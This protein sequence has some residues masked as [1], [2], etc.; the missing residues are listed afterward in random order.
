MASIGGSGLDVQGIVSQ[1]MNIER[2][3]LRLIDRKIS[4]QE[5]KISALGRLSSSLTDLKN[6]ADKLQNSSKFGQFKAESSDEKVLTASASSLEVEET[7]SIE[8]IAL[9]TRHRV[10]SE[11]VYESSA[12]SVGAGS[13][14]FSAGK[15]EFEITL[16]EGSS[17]LSDLSNAINRASDNTGINASII[18]VDDGYRLVL[19]GRKSGTENVITAAGDWEQLEQAQDA[20]IKVDGLTIHPSSNTVTGV[21]PGVTL[22]LKTTGAVSLNTGA[23]KEKMLETLKDFA[24][25]YNTVQNTLKQLNKGDLKGEG[26]SVSIDTAIRNN[27]FKSFENAEGSSK[28]AFDFGF[29]FDKSGQLSVDESKVNESID[30]DLYGML[31]FF[32]KEDSFANTMTNSIS[33]L[34]QTGGVLDSRKNAFNNSVTRF[35]SRAE[36]LENRLERINERYLKTY[37]ELDRLV[38]QMNGTSNGIIQSLSALNNQNN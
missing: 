11:T 24:K 12:D 35:E 3:P 28:T 31:N 9:A 21:I 19:S 6:S 30:S 14:T 4:E 16:E 13:Y 18:H 1:L 15:D 17:S 2:A 36:R 10:A 25:S 29:T 34:T 8:I 38:T 32:T 20:T 27:F 5:N 22:A 7:H 26:L 37:S 33:A 23:D